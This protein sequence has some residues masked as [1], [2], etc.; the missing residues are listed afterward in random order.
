MRISDALSP[1]YVLLLKNTF[2]DNRRVFINKKHG[3]YDF[4]IPMRNKE[5]Q[6]PGGLRPSDLSVSS[7]SHCVD[8]ASVY[9]VKGGT[10]KMVR[11]EK[12]K[13]R[14]TLSA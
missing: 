5:R 9:G 13:P 7:F 14:K 4:N 10:S 11:F 3:Q 2:K 8:H 1:E 12:P 6:R